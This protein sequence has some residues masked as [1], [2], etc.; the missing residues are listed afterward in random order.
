MLKLSTIDFIPE[1]ESAYVGRRSSSC[2]CLF[3]DGHILQ[4]RWETVAARRRM[5][6]CLDDTWWSYD[7]RGRMW[8]KFTDICLAIEGKPR[9]TVNQEMTRPGIEPASAAWG[10]TMLPLDHSGGHISISYC[11]R[12]VSGVHRCSCSNKANSV[13]GTDVSSSPSIKNQ[14]K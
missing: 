3:N 1:V 14:L 5:I 2:C 13:V 4:L 6:Y 12:R 10:V 7:N 9:K 11:A 8:P